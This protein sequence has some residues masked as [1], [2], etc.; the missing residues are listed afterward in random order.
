MDSSFLTF[1]IVGL[2]LFT[3]VMFVKLL[4]QFGLP[5]HPMKLTAYMVS[6]CVTVFFVTRAS[7]SL[8]FL[9]PWF[10]I[11]WQPLPMVTGSLALLLQVIVSTT[12]MSLVQQKVVSRL[13]LIA[14]LLFLAFFP[15][16]AEFFVTAI[17]V[18]GCIF[19]TV[20]VGKARYQKR[21]YVKMTL[22][23]ALGLGLRLI[24]VYW[25]YVAAELLMFVSLFYFFLFEQCFGVSAITQEGQS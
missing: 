10:W 6:F 20:S 7:V 17:I 5:N 12:N 11:R 22:F 19:L 4:I 13:P 3:L 2:G 21:L 23:L 16:H 8:G 25:T 1:V 18:A 24:N 14:G 9:A 15:T